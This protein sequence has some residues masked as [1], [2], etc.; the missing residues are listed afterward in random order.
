MRLRPFIKKRVPPGPGFF[1]SCYSV[2]IEE[3]SNVFFALL[4]SYAPFSSGCSLMDTP[5]FLN[6]TSFH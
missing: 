2:G 5:I 4:P 3:Q 1:P 6:E